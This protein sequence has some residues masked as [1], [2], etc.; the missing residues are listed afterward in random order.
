MT[1]DAKST[2]Q[3]MQSISDLNEQLQ[4]TWDELPPGTRAKLLAQQMNDAEDL[5]EEEARWLKEES[6]RTAEEFRE[7]FR[8]LL[9]WRRDAAQSFVESMQPLVE[10]AE[11][12]ENNDE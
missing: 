12:I 9:E 7:A 6:E 2:R 11:D 4:E 1:D 5:A 3:T 10:L 8:P